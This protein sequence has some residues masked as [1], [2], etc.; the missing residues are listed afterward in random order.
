MTQRIPS[1]RF[2]KARNCAVVT[3]AGKN[4]YLGAYDSSESWEKYYRLVA[5]FLAKQN[6]P[7]PPPLPA[8]SP[9]TMTELAALYWKHAAAYYLKNGHPT[10]EQAAIKQALRFVR[11]LYGTTPARDFGPQRLIAV[12]EAMIKHPITCRVNRVDPVTGVATKEPKTLRQGLTRKTINNAVGRI[13]RMFAWAVEEEILPVD[14]HSALHRVRG[15]RRGKSA[16]RESPRVRPVPAEH[17]EAVLRFLPRMVQDMI[18]VHQL[19]GGRPQDIVQLRGDAID[20]SG[21]IWEYRPANYK[22]EHHNDQNDPDLDRVVCF[23]PHAQEILG[24]YLALEPNGYL[25]SPIR[26]EKTRNEIR[27][28]QRSTTVTPSQTARRPRGRPWGP[29]RDHYDVASYRRAIRRACRKAGIPTWHPNRLRHSRLTEIRRLYG[30]EAS[31][32]CGGHREVGVTQHYAEQDR[33]LARH[34]MREIG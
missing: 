32:V 23:G 34:V 11:R 18:R 14:V 31:R 4:H 7:Q 10:S 12:R 16:A 26:S 27:R 15:L 17:V 29:L 28:D 2:H 5:E 3:L 25:F 24:P 8:D 6:A 20:R 22:T 30:L 19:C 1:Y 9:L 33:D 13:K 21:S